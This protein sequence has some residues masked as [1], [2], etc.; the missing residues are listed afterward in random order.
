[1]DI[2]SYLSNVRTKRPLVHSIT[3]YVSVG[4]CADIIESSGGA[5]IMAQAIEEMEELVLKADALYI[6]IGTLSSA[7]LPSMFSAVSLAAQNNIS[8]VLDPV[9]A[10]AT[11]YRTETALKLLAQ[12]EFALVR[13]NISEIRALFG[14]RGRTRG[15]SASEEDLVQE[16]DLDSLGTMARD[17]ARERNCIIGIS[18]STDII[19]SSSRICFVRNGHSIMPRLTGTGCML[20]ALCAVFLAANPLDSFEAAA[21]AFCMMGLCGEIAAKELKEGEG[22][23]SWRIRFLDAVARL[24]PEELEKGARYEMR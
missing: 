16:S 1:M 17:F 18:G 14:F 5:P 4:D 8:A 24:T 22:P 15:V 2:S 13:G 10:G 19:A 7:V 3:N 12:G 23:A 9:G 20:S 6:N 11:E 21:A